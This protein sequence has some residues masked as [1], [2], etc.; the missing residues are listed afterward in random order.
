MTC[1]HC[2]SDDWY[3]DYLGS[4]TGIVD[5][6]D[7]RITVHVRCDCASCGRMFFRDEE[8]AYLGPDRVIWEVDA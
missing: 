4:D 5:Y 1:P 2:G 7:G 6:M 8:Y 3:G